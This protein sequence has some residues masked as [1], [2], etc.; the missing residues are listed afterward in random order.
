MLQMITSWAMPELTTYNKTLKVRSGQRTCVF[1]T[2]KLDY[3]NLHNYYR[4]RS[5][6][7][8]GAY[9]GNL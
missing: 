1:S 8:A 5:H 2:V 3:N 9:I 4:K 7:G 6:S